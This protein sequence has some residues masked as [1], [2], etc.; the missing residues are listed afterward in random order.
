M[1]KYDTTLNALLATSTEAL[2]LDP[3]NETL[4]TGILQNQVKLTAGQLGISTTQAANVV[5]SYTSAYA[6]SKG[7]DPKAVLD[8]LN[9]AQQ[10]ILNY[11]ANKPTL[12]GM[13]LVTANKI[14]SYFAASAGVVLGLSIVA[15]LI[16]LFMIGPELAAAIAGA[17]GVVE[18]LG[19]VTGVAV[20]STGGGA[21]AVGTFL[22]LISQFLGHMGGSIPLWTK[23][24]VDNGTIAASLQITAIKNVAEVSAQLTG[25]KAPGPYSS[26]QFSS[27]YNG[28]AAAGFSQVKNPVTGELAPFSQQTLAQLINYLY[29]TQIGIGAPATPSKITPLLNAWL[30][31]GGS[32]N[33][34]PVSLYDQVLGMTAPESTPTNAGG[35]T[36]PTTTPA[37]TGSASGV[38]APATNIQ[39]YTGV[40]SGGTLGLPQEF[41]ATTSSMISSVADLTTA[42]QINLAAAVQSLPGRF[43]YEI[44]VV[45][46]IKTKS[47]FTQRGAPVTIVTG[48]YKNGKPKTKTIYMK[49]AQMRL[50][51]TDENGKTVRL[52]TIN[53]GPVDVT[54]FSPSTVQLK[55]VQNSITGSTFTTN[56]AAIQSVVSPTPVTVSTVPPVNPNPPAP[57]VVAPTPVV[58]PTY[59]PPPAPAPAP[60]P[61]ETLAKFT[62][63]SDWAG[64]LQTVYY[65]DSAGAIKNY[66]TGGIVAY[67]RDPS[68]AS[69]LGISWYNST[70]NAQAAY[71]RYLQLAATVPASSVSSPAPTTSATPK[72]AAAAAATT[73]S[74]FYTAIG[75]A[76]PS[77]ATRANLFQTYGLGPSS[78]Y[79]GS[80]D[81]NN[82]LLGMLKLTYA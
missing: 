4:R 15:F 20:G 7:Q 18:A 69:H 13:D 14:A 74:D 17:G 55:D 67:T 50:G 71:S 36:S 42:A 57:P 48:S 37:V 31:K 51:V 77:L 3:H 23:Q 82:K 24:M 54:V 59:T 68:P 11:D 33:P 53:L 12:Y 9:A 26:T 43:Y 6:Y 8:A 2:R 66:S 29:G 81:Q 58:T 27:L 45:N 22:F 46:E 49:F 64:G 21:I 44:S 76:L 62:Y 47:G 79:V 60:V 40:I 25:T 5:R 19:A 72:N 38:V 75:Q 16:A 78:S 61:Q 10:Q 35:A 65:D 56:V 1:P 39:I 34:I 41:H 80:A 73:L 52:A 32:N 30:Y 28:L 70:P 63:N